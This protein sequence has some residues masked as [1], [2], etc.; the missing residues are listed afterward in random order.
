MR[1]LVIAKSVAE[2]VRALISAPAPV[3]ELW[4]RHPRVVEG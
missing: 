4:V 2:L 1:V 3:K